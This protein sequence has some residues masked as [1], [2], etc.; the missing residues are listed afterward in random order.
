LRPEASGPQRPA[1]RPERFHEALVSA[2]QRLYPGDAQ[3]ASAELTALPPF[4]LVLLLAFY[5][6]Y[7]SRGKVPKEKLQSF[8]ESSQ[9]AGIRLAQ[10]R[11]QHSAHTMQV[12][13]LENA[14]GS[15][16]RSAR[17]GRDVGE[18]GISTGT[19]ARREHIFGGNKL[20]P[21]E[22]ESP[23]LLL[24]R[25]VFGGIFNIM[26]WTCVACELALVFF[27][28][29]DDVVTPIVLSL[30]IVSSGTLQW[31]TERQAE[32]MMSA[33]QKMQAASDV[34]VFRPP[35]DGGRG[36]V[37][38]SVSTENLVPGDVL[39][40]EAGQRVP[41]DVRVLACT[42]GSLVDNSALTGESVAE[43]RTPNVAPTGQPL[44]EARNIAFCGTNV[45]QGRMLCVVFGIGDS[46][47]LGQIAAKIRTSR[48][49]SSLEIQIEHF[50]HIVAIVAIGVGLLSLVA[51]WL[52]PRKRGAA[53]ILEN[54]ATAFFAQVPE[55]LLPTVTVCLM[56]ASRQMSKRQ[57]LVRKIDA[58]ETLG[59]VSILCSDKTGTLTSGKMTATDLVVP[60]PVADAPAGGL[61]EVVRLGPDCGAK[62][63]GIATGKELTKLAR[64]GMLNNAAK[65]DSTGALSGSPTEV[66][67]FAGCSD[68]LAEDPENLRVSFP[69]IFE[70][71]FNSAAKWMLTV[72][73]L[74][75][76]GQANAPTTR[77]P[78][79]MDDIVAESGGRP[80]SGFVAVLKGAPERVL[81]MCA[82]SSE[83]RADIEAAMVKLTEQGKRVLCLAERHLKDLAPDFVFK[84]SGADDANFPM[85]DFEFRGL[86]ALE[87]PPKPGAAE[88]VEKIRR[89]G[90][91]TVMV[92][93]DH[94][95]TAE[96]IA[97]RIGVIP[98][99]DDE[100]GYA[101]ITGAQ[102]EEQLPP[103]DCF[104]PAAMKKDAS[105]E[106]V[107]FWRSC[108]KHTCVFARVSPMHKR[109]IVRAFQHFGGHI[110]AMTGDGVNDAPAL[111]EAEVG[112]A[113]GIR[114]TE[115]AKEAADI[116]LLDDD[117]QSVV[118]GMEQGRLC[119][120]NLRK[121][122]MY[123]LCSKVPQVMP[124]FME[125]LGVPTALTAAQVLLVD[126]GTD[127][128]TAI[129][130]AWQP[131]ESELMERAPRHPKKDR[132]VNGQ[133]LLYSYGY[134]G[135]VQMFACW[136]VF[137]G[138]MPHMYALF[139]QDKHPSEYSVRDVE[140]DYAATT[141]YYW[142]LVLGQVGA[143]LATTTTRTSIFKFGIPNQWLNACLVLEICLALLV[144][145]WSPL[146]SLFKTRRL[147][148]SQLLAGMLGFVLIG[149]LEELRKYWLRRQEPLEKK[150][151]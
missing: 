91:R 88:A 143:A 139:V 60:L 37:E 77:E 79:P 69:Q 89:A 125:L 16:L 63:I 145:M 138:I 73:A 126:I 22:R 18:V 87:D 95:S 71:P 103:N 34:T 2:K 62:D 58:V 64:C 150:R 9:E 42:D 33:L 142:T 92:T 136:V 41:A 70:I 31:W 57:V 49:R 15:A 121:S 8:H 7:S 76:D 30:V 47:F 85:L 115:V 50:V 146:Q 83:L 67:I 56:I 134:I 144:M 43:P 96:A 111:K 51:N 35:A 112:I 10:A 54:A 148:P 11:V 117:L 100:G 40:L 116:V 93:G 17:I 74:G 13:E 140:S 12:E 80:S 38:V 72:H 23:W 14:L 149:V 135:M 114:G 3:L 24:L 131:A 97:R 6:A 84:G 45:L 128:W 26:L 132:M 113:M 133:L 101:V 28:G 5:W 20:T 21:P 81:P 46:T 25:Q 32:S 1:Q 75:E 55:G 105:P 110:T 151:P 66:A 104:D 59:C 109:T 82:T 120:E 19:A 61:L 86:V 27:L 36:S 129:A 29:G 122:I 78:L 68:V 108:V 141:A 39:M 123:T 130:Y 102:L 118:A 65:V 90:A 52:S 98:A 53:E 4:G 137:F 48:T 107:F 106:L 99:D 119:S 94:P 127:I 147:E 44:A 124:T